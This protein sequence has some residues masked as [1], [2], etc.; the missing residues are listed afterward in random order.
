[1]SGK[2]KKINIADTGGGG[3][4]GSGTSPYSHTFSIGSWGSPSGGEYSFTVS[5]TTHLKGINPLVQIYESSGGS[6]I[7]VIQYLEINSSGDITLKINELPD[8]RYAGKLII[9]D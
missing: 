4:G 7:E 5:Q 1:M 6:F 8:I 2:Y 3:G 9:G